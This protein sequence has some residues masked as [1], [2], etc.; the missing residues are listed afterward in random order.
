MG[1]LDLACS[2]DAA[3]G[4]N[5]KR[6]GYCAG[7][8][9]G[10]I[11]TFGGAR[12]ARNFRDFLPIGLGAGLDQGG[13]RCGSARRSTW[14]GRCGENGG[15]LRFVGHGLGVVGLTLL[16][17]N[18]LARRNAGLRPSWRKPSRLRR[19]CPS[20]AAIEGGGCLFGGTGGTP[21]S[22]PARSASMQR[23]AIFRISDRHSPASRPWPIL[24][25]R[26]DR[27]IQAIATGSGVARD[28]RQL[29]LGGFAWPRSIL[30]QGV[31]GHGSLW[32]GSG[33]DAGTHGLCLGGARVNA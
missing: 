31:R 33:A 7:V 15:I 25:V 12:R 24:P 9:L 10:S 14:S 30:R 11:C 28:Q 2:A 27:E 22:G 20:W 4:P 1:A 29:G 23:H 21:P 5:I 17:R 32:H 19:R 18:A 13:D 3:T 16:D 6:A 26:D 8:E